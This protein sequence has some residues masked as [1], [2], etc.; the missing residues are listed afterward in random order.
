MAK[1]RIKP[2]QFAHADLIVSEEGL[3][4]S[5]EQLKSMEELFEGEGS[6]YRTGQ[7]VT[8]KVLSVDS[9][10]VLVDINYKSNGMIPLYE[11]SEHELKEVQAGSDL[12]VII[13][14]LEN[15]YGDVVLSYENALKEASNLKG[16]RLIDVWVD[17]DGYKEQLKS[18]RG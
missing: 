16:P 1:E 8:G 2:S 14:D 5:A 15:V 11:F 4:L 18:L 12:E 7:L 13:D 10:G 6:K 3:E 9:D 17:P